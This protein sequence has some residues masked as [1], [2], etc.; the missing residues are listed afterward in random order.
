MCV[1][2]KDLP[3]CYHRPR[4]KPRS[5][6]RADGKCNSSWQGQSRP[7]CFVGLTHVR[8]TDIAFSELS[9]ALLHAVRSG[10]GCKNKSESKDWAKYLGA[11]AS[12][13]VFWIEQ[14]FHWH[15]EKCFVGQQRVLWRGA[16][17]NGM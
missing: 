14:G 10:E 17:T 16:T 15:V 6:L 8:V 2:V 5:A 12:G 1:R 7:I 3:D 4:R 11:M 13:D 9:T